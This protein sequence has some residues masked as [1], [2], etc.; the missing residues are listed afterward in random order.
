MK[1]IQKDHPLVGTWITDD[2]DSNVAV[3]IEV[4]RGR[5]RVSSFTRSDGEFHKITHLKWNGKT[6]SFDSTVPSNGWRTKH[7]FSAGP[8][9][10]ANVEFTWFELWK[11]KDVK[12]GEVPEAWRKRK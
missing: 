8:H 4:R 7:V 11:E 5:F 1:T 2:E 9:G 3:V 10:F 6:L 12:P